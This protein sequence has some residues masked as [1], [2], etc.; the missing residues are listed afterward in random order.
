MMKSKIEKVVRDLK[1]DCEVEFEDSIS[2]F[3]GGYGGLED[4]YPYLQRIVKFANLNDSKKQ[5][6]IYKNL[7]G[8]CDEAYFHL[9]ECM[10]DRFDDSYIVKTV[11]KIEKILVDQK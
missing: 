3:P 9:N 8:F 11:N 2:G 7:K 10:W 4:V 5:N 6:K 1:T